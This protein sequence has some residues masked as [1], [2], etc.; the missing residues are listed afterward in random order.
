MV[1]E[2]RDV[3]GFEDLYKVSN[4]GQIMS[5]RRFR[6][7]KNGHPVTVYERILKYKI[8]KDGYHGV[9]L[10]RDSVHCSLRVHRIV[11]IAFIPNEQ[12]H[13]QVNHK[14][15]NKANNAVDNLEWT[16]DQGNKDHCRRTVM[17]D[18]RGENHVL[19][20]LKSADVVKIRELYK[21]GRTQVRIATEYGIRQAHVSSIVHKKTWKHI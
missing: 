1:I 20:K 19:A 15:S 6:Q 13:P 21:G 12:N 4:E 17:V 11:A 16:T 18:Y 2:W 10:S 9:T 3:V 7:G 14:D 5:L 8:D